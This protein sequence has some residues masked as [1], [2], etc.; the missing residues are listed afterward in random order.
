MSGEQIERFESELAE[1]LGAMKD[2]FREF[3][4]RLGEVVSA[5]RLASSEARNEA[6]KAR[7]ALEELVRAAKT[8]VEAQ[9]QA[10]TEL[11]QGWQLHVAENSKAAGREM[12]R[13]FGEEMAGGLQQSLAQL[14]GRAEIATRRLTWQTHALWAMGVGVGIALLVMF[15]IHTFTP[16][17]DELSIPG[18]SAM[19]THEVLSRITLCWPQPKNLRDA[20]VCVVTDN[21]PQLTRGPHSE[22][23]VVVRGM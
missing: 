15:G 1:A 19:Q 16:T 7:A 10:L 13:A 3:E 18:L 9:R 17:V 22:A 21:P 5:Q 23:A 11:R 12:A 14:A 2:L 4:A 20:H 8:L 6:T